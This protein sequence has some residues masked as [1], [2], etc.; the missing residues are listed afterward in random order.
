MNL[1]VGG[2]PEAFQTPDG[3]SVEKPFFTG[4]GVDLDRMSLVIVKE[5][6]D[7][8]RLEFGYVYTVE[9][10]ESHEKIKKEGIAVVLWERNKKADDYKGYIR[11]KDK[12]IEELR[13]AFKELLN[14][15]L[16]VGSA[17]DIEDVRELFHL[18]TGLMQIAFPTPDG[19]NIGGGKSEEEGRRGIGA[20]AD[21]EFISAR[22][23]KTA[24]EQLRVDFYYKTRKD[25]IIREEPASIAWDGLSYI[26]PS[27]DMGLTDKEFRM[28]VLKGRILE[29][30]LYRFFAKKQSD[31]MSSSG[32]TGG[33]MD[34]RLRGNDRGS[35]I[36][37]EREFLV[38]EF[39]K[40]YRYPTFFVEGEFVGACKW[41][42]SAH[43][44]VETVL[45]L[46][47][48][49]KL[50]GRTEPIRLIVFDAAKVD[51][52][53]EALRATQING[54]PYEIIP[55]SELLKRTGP[56]NGDAVSMLETLKDVRQKEL[57]G[58]ETGLEKMYASLREESGAPV[59]RYKKGLQLQHEAD[60]QSHL[61][62]H[63]IEEGPEKI[64][65]VLDSIQEHQSPYWEWAYHLRLIAFLSYLYQKVEDGRVRKR[66]L[67]IYPDIEKDPGAW[68]KIVQYYKLR[69]YG[70]DAEARIHALIRTQE[71][72]ESEDIEEAEEV[73]APAAERKSRMTHA[74]AFDFGRFE[75]TVD[76]TISRQMKRHHITD[77]DKAV[78]AVDMAVTPDVKAATLLETIAE[79]RKLF[80]RVT[81][82]YDPFQRMSLFLSQKKE[83]LKDIPAAERHA[84]LRQVVQ[85]FV[86]YFIDVKRFNDS[87]YKF[88]TGYK[89]GLGNVGFGY[90][91]R[92]L[93]A[94]GNLILVEDDFGPGV[95]GSRL[96]NEFETFAKTLGIPV[97][98]LSF[99]P[100]AAAASGNVPIPAAVFFA[101]E[102][103]RRADRGK[104]V[105]TPED[106]RVILDFIGAIK[107][108]QQRV[109]KLAAA[110]KG[111]V[112][113][114]QVGFNEAVV[115]DLHDQVKLTGP[116]SFPEKLE[117]RI[118]KFAQGIIQIFSHE[119]LAQPS[120]YNAANNA[121]YLRVKNIARMKEL[122]HEIGRA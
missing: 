4:A 118:V 89:G 59:R 36:E 79:F 77:L 49:Q 34:S 87:R 1:Q 63:Y 106:R 32:L 47:R 82:P 101:D 108:D 73:P 38:D 74:A 90:F 111:G 91:L 100:H 93:D 69:E 42:R 48:L 45:K 27:D 17:R 98:R 35:R 11:R 51:E 64:L 43:S 96:L 21:L 104:L 57:A 37:F 99:D 102:I 70:P 120:M 110:A 5:S 23:V 119:G 80:A 24:D 22:V 97:P 55:A 60:W 88:F 39:T 2:T 25:K 114:N 122:L 75:V 78:P 58:D 68:Q 84:L 115:K 95:S 29:E 14:P 94:T 72:D 107:S 112:N 113:T 15:A 86:M 81:D 3:E 62:N 13:N 92:S 18:P 33:S 52:A 85:A 65:S 54:I 116:Q 44:I 28:R 76:R 61:I 9:D 30:L 16:P 66:I 71:L 109:V 31:T 8:Y 50:S 19:G 40:E 117:E 41:G 53:M 105:R 6:Q 46:S 56:P 26:F 83:D 67:E 7:R 103:I 121:L 12:Q 20:S 10:E